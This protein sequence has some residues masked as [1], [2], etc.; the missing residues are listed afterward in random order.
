[1]ISF[2]FNL[3]TIILKISIFEYESYDESS[4]RIL[5][6]ITSLI[7]SVPGF[8]SGLL[9]MK[10]LCNDTQENRKLLPRAIMIIIIA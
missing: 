4:L 1:M 9:F 6:I 5:Y 7:L 8:A 2:I 3:V 10:W